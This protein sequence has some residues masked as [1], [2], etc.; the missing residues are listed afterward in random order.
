MYTN[1]E[2]NETQV[3]NN[4][5]R[6]RT[7]EARTRLEYNVKHETFTEGKCSECGNNKRGLATENQKAETQEI[8]K[9]ERSKLVGWVREIFIMLI[10]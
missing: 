10:N 2:H 6:S 9:D 8:R 3:C 5:G 1:G 4:K 7:A